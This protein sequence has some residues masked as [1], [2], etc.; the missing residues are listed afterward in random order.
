LI[1]ALKLR[2]LI[3]D[4]KTGFSKVLSQLEAL[5]GKFS[6]AFPNPTGHPHGIIS[7]KLSN[8]KAFRGGYYC[9]ISGGNIQIA[10]IY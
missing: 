10:C 4:T 1:F 2:F 7:W 6:L 5:P 8:M 9:P 3:I